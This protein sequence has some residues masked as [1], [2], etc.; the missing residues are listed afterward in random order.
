MGGAFSM[1]YSGPSNA[2]KPAM[3]L[4]QDIR[5]SLRSLAKTPTF[6]IV[7]LLSLGLGIGANTAIFSLIDQALLRS[8]PVQNPSQLVLL[9]ANGPRSGNI[10][11]SYGDQYTFSYPMYRDFRDRNRVFSGVL[12]RFPI[13]F[14]FTS[15][16]QTERVYGDLVS[17][18][19]FEV[20]GVQAAVGRTLWPEDD[21]LPG[22]HAVVVLSHS[23]WQR[24]FGADQAV[25]NQ[26]VTLN[27]H[28]MTIV[29]VTRKGFHGVGT[30]EAPEVFVPMAMRADMSPGRADLE[31]RR[32]MWLNIFARLKP[33]VSPQ[34][35][36]TAMN[37]FWRPL[38]EEEAKAL[39]A[40][41]SQATRKRFQERHITLLPGGKGIS[42]APPGFSAAMLVLMGMVGVLLLIACAN[43][44]NLLIARA[45]ARQ[46]E[47]GIRLALGASRFRIVRQLLVE[48]LLLAMGGGTLG[49]L[50]A[51][52]TGD[53]LLGFL[54][55]DPTSAGLSAHTDLRVLL[56]A[57][58]L[59]LLTG[60][61]F[62]LLPALQ[63]TRPDLAN[64][65]KG[66]AST[67]MGGLSHARLRKTLVAAQVALSLVLLVTAGL[68]ARSLWN[69]KNIDTG[70][71]TDHLISFS[72]APVLNGYTQ[73]AMQA[74]L[75]R[76]R[77][78]LASLPGVRAVSLAQEPVLSGDIDIEAFDLAGYQARE[79]ENM[80]VNVNMVG[81]GYFATM[82]IPLLAGRDFTDGDTPAAPLVA[83][84]N[85]AMAQKYFGHENPLGRRLRFRKSSGEIQI[86]GVVR[87]A[88]YTGLREEKLAFVYF[89]YAQQT[90]NHATFYCRT[91]QDPL[92]TVSALRQAIHGVD[93][94]LP[95]FGVKTL[96]GQI[97]ESIF[98]DR[99]VAAL[100]VMFGVLA[101]ILAA[102]GLY[103]VMAYMVIGRTREIGIRVALGADRNRVL[104]LVLRE[105]ALLVGGGI[106]VALLASIGV[107]RLIDSQLFGVTGHDPLVLGAATAVLAA[108]ALFASY[109]PALRATRVNPLIALRYE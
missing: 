29:G 49:I 61:L 9:S 27:G 88:K 14:S 1:A 106:M 67:G 26:N 93:P 36:E 3:T 82:G 18:N 75:E 40:R 6:T 80:S 66:Q 32:S 15:Q 37:V 96:T 51:T 84:I 86:A 64:N 100:S 83:I 44:A 16:D 25:L 33:G 85:E 53:L 109:L 17:G 78:S 79:D 4:A 60:L 94:N 47:T 19:Y 41:V 10:D 59:S 95:I 89:P 102:V 45:S 38:L 42:S 13:S 105:A 69:V 28:R 58:A 8:L 7:A 70:F 55:E 97:D 87:N 11:T 50:A 31:N 52:W 103:G 2:H 99:L 39:P 108:V 22:A 74:L 81:P 63:S 54:P 43:V 46:K 68:F 91:T 21:G 77:H 12:A 30:G 73:P 71:P 104:R 20:L 35:A 62:G 23:F 107:G 5:Y 56:F 98:T 34:Q 57:V 48:S 24:R 72:V 65:L 90:A 92:A 76:M 101:T